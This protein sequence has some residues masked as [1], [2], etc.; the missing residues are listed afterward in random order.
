MSS[1]GRP[2][3]DIIA[4]LGAIAPLSLAASWD[5]TGLL[6]AGDGR[7]VS[8]ALLAIDVVP[9][10]L[11]EARRLDAQL[12]VGYHPLIFTPLARLDGATWQGRVALEAVRAG[13]AVYSPHTAL[14]AVEGGI[15]DWLVELA[16]QAGG[17]RVA[18][19]GALEPAAMPGANT[20]KL[21]T[22]VPEAGVDAVRDALAAAGA[23][24]IGLYAHCSFTTVGEGSFIGGE[25]A[26]PA[27]GEVG[28]HERV[29]ECRLE[30]AFPEGAAR[31]GR[32][33]PAIRASL[34]GAGVPHS[35]ARGASRRRAHGR[36]EVRAA[37]QAVFFRGNR[38]K[39][40]SAPR[41]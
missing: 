12:I 4:A 34:R 25:G 3:N 30:M 5:K 11:A 6:V 35:R 20:H 2:L 27:V 33:R 37:Q 39:S 19:C 21:V 40:P 32:R 7:S 1:N 23:G 14:D 24:R 16:A 8:R 15:N 31:R 13:I 26:R 10:V 9:E 29:R 41:M 38:G 17:A 36:R 22:F 28:R 18:E